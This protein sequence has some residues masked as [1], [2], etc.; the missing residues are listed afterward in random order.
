MIYQWKDGFPTHGADAQAV[1][2]RLES[3]REC[4]QGK[5]TPEAIVSDAAKPKS[6]MHSL[7]EWDD[8][9]AA[10]E[11]RLEQARALLRAIVTTVVG[12]HRTTP[13]RAFV[14]VKQEGDKGKSYTSIG[15]AMASPVLR[16]QV[17]NAAKAELASWRTRYRDL[18]ELTALFEIVDE[19][20]RLSA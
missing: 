11:Y 12:A 1:G 7:F 19:H 6:P 2:A 20:L 8:E 3:L 10:T 18:E 14:A 5:L 16:S 17:L 13:T 9:S 15:V 4:H